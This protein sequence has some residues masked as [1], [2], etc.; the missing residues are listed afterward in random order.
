MTNRLEINPPA[1]KFLKKIKEKTLQQKFRNALEEILQSPFEA[2]NAKR[3]NLSGV[4]GYDVYHNGTNYEIV[5]MIQKDEEGHLVIIVLV[6]TRER[7]YEQLKRY[8]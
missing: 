6:G 4:Y 2:A 3:G 5:Y 1:K 8:W 7:F